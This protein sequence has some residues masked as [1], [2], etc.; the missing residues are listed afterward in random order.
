[1]D[2]LTQ[3]QINDKQKQFVQRKF[4][5]KVE[6]ALYDSFS[7]GLAG[8]MQNARDPYS[9]AGAALSAI[10]SSYFSYRRNLEKYKEERD[11]KEW[12]IDSQ[13]ML[14]LNNTRKKFFKISWDLIQ[15]YKF[16]DQPIAERSL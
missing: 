16:P 3:S 4:E 11:E 5:R 2:I 12:E 8:A 15:K 14:D 6:N 1:M 7:T 10:G 9:A 13:I